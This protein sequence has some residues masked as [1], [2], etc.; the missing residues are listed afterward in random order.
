MTT[1][2]MYSKLE[3]SMSLSNPDEDVGEVVSFNVPIN[4]LSLF[5]QEYIRV[6][7]VLHKMEKNYFELASRTPAAE[8]GAGRSSV[9][10]SFS[11]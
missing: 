10:N 9:R 8:S 4:C 11:S 2:E 6:K 5:L 7:S 1:S 3:T